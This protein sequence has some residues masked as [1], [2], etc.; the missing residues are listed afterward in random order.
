MSVSKFLLVCTVAW[1][2]AAGG[3]P[4]AAAA[5]QT[6]ILKVAGIGSPIGAWTVNAVLKYLKGVTDAK[7]SFFTKLVRV[8]YD[9]EQILPAE[10]IKALST[11]THYRASLPTSPPAR[12]RLQVVGLNQTGFARLIFHM[13]GIKPPV[14]TVNRWAT[15]KRAIPTTV[16]TILGLLQRLPFPTLA[17]L[18]RDAGIKSRLTSAP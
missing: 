14:V 3:L 13:S 11:Q 18:Y 12:L 15:G 8:E 1:T 16:P 7:A 5:T 2:L 10:M 9:P 6:V 17:A 4:Q